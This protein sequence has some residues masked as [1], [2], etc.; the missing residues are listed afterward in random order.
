M[1]FNEIFLFPFERVKRGTD[2]LLYGMGNVGKCFYNQVISLKYCNILATVDRK[3][4]EIADK[5]GPLR[6][7]MI[8][9]EQIAGYN[10]DYII[11]AIASV[12]IARQ[13]KNELISK[14]SVPEEKIIFVPN[15]KVRVSL[16]D[17]DLN[18]WMDSTEVMQRELYNFWL[19]RVGDVNY[20][21][22]I[23]KMICKLNADHEIDKVK[24]IKTYFKN[25][26]YSNDSVKNKIVILRILYMSD[27]FD[28]ELM[29]LYLSCISQ[30][31]NY[32][33]R[34][35]MIYDISIIEGNEQSCRYADYYIDKRKL[36]E[37]NAN[38]YY[39]MTAF[40]PV[41][42]QDN[43]I[44]IVSFTLGNERSSHNALIIPYA[45]EMVRQGRKV[46]IFPMDLL[47]YRYGE[48]F[49]QPLVPLE[50]NAKNSEEFHKECLDSRI[51]VI[52][53]KG[54]SIKERICN[55]MGSLIHYNPHVVY[56]F[57]GEYSFLSSLINKIFY[58]IALPIRGYASSACFD[59]YMCRNK[60]ICINENKYY[61][62]VKEKQMV[63]ALVCT[64][65]VQAGQ[66]YKRSDYK[67]NEKAF[68]ITTVG[69]RLVKELTPEFVDCV[70]MFLKE[71]ERACWILVGEKI[72]GY[73]NE[74]Y[75]E[76][77]MKEQIIEWG[78]EENLM[79]FYGICDIYWNPNR[80]GAGGS[81]AMAMRCGLPIVT[82]DFPSDVLPRLGMENAIKGD[83]FDCK[84]YVEKLYADDELYKEKSKLM[85]DR[86]HISSVEEY[87]RKLLEV[88][89]TY[90]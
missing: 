86:M 36:M 63:E 42:T 67:I 29:E 15:R 75:S 14:Y 1:R 69:E 56:D 8:C 26:L 34:M 3:A 59:I 18:Q 76:L 41:A 68:V 48:C 22:N 49:I 17:T 54:E 81:I 85:Q 9:P 5:I 10:Y 39:N 52:Y 21:D 89:D 73:V 44:A 38:Y 30:L 83:Y 64:Y 61:H 19:T 16:A 7:K 45:N 50:Q 72:N 20:F 58:T 84:K 65:P 12:G 78:Y 35:W 25:Y 60:E 70:C 27:C 88:G 23:V 79:S 33:A 80:M 53:N 31:D 82:T 74:Y 2:I 11:I 77:I 24:E 66:K 32:D 43:K 37:E 4:D 51:K 28:S 46:T 90:A 6:Y 47:Q 13:I 62:S 55:F 40:H 87:V 57:C 71:H